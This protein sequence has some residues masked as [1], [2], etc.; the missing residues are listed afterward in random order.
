MKTV[1]LRKELK[2]E[3]VTVLIDTRENEILDVSPL[4]SRRA[5]LTTGDYSAAG[6]QSIIAIERKSL[7][8]MVGSLTTE[9]DRFEREIM[10]MLAYP[11]RALIIEAN[12]CDIELKAYRGQAHPNSIMGSLMSFIAQGIPV[13]MIGDHERAGKWVARMIYLAAKRRYNENLP[14]ME[15]VLESSG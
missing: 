6:M 7:Q 15:N 11:V 14:F 2:P 1:T 13:I 9:R 8:D 10:R 4:K 3:Q 5:T 12:W